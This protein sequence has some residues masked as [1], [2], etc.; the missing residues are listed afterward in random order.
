MTKPGLHS[1]GND[2]AVGVPKPSAG[3]KFIP[4]ELCSS[5]AF[6]R[7]GDASRTRSIVCAASG[8]VREV[9]KLDPLVSTPPKART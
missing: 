3:S 9:A 7:S 8:D 2:A 5:N 1:Q 4:S 6:T